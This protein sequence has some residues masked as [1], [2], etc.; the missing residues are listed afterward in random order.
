MDYTFTE[1]KECH[2]A[3]MASIIRRNLENAGLDIPGTAYFDKNLDSLSSYY[4]KENRK[5]FV[6]LKGS[7]VAGGAGFAPFELSDSCAEMQKLY[8]DNAEKGQGLGYRLVEKV[9][10]EMRKAGFRTVYLET[11]HSLQAAIHLYR[12]C[13]YREIERPDGVVHSTMDLFF[14]KE[15][16]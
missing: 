3:E 4:G 9:E 11:H 14:V 8:L 1:I 7:K 6:L 16:F 15:L 10:E 5:Y 2:N 12:R 13:G